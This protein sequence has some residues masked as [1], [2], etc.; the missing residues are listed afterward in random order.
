MLKFTLKEGSVGTTYVYVEMSM[1]SF[2]RLPPDAGVGCR[3]SI[4]S[5]SWDTMPVQVL[6]KE[7]SMEILDVCQEPPAPTEGL[8][9]GQS[10][11]EL[12]HAKLIEVLEL[13]AKR[14]H[15]VAP[16]FATDARAVGA[17][18]VLCISYNDDLYII[19][20]AKHD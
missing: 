14:H 8:T 6:R 3:Y 18:K 11:H 13:A 20:G 15:M 17:P 10:S 2:L 1:D 5:Q 12:S 4:G 9:E 7:Y 19:G 16:S